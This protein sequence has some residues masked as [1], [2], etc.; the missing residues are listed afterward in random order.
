MNYLSM[1]MKLSKEDI[2]FLNIYF[3]SNKE[4]N[5]Y[6]GIIILASAKEKSLE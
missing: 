5:L 4:A 6:S 3:V 2:H 1:S